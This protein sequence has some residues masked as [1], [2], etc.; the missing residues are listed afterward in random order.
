MI[1]LL[2]SFLNISEYT[3]II[4]SNIIDE[5]DFDSILGSYFDFV[6]L[7]I[8]RRVFVIYIESIRTFNDVW[9]GGLSRGV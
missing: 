4:I 1:F 7:H 9:I 5:L 2:C 3:Y 8:F 6:N